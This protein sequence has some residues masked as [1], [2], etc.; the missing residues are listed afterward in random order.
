MATSLGNILGM[1]YTIG[2]ATQTA[3]SN[4]YGPWWT[5]NIIYGNST[6]TA[7]NIL[8]AP[9]YQ[10]IIYQQMPQVPPGILN[11]FYSTIPGPPYQPPET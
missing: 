1:T 6:Q 9:Y 3:T 4:P 8:Y 5:D 11:P 10:Q 2:A 7:Q